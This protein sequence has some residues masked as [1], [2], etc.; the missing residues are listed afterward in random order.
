MSRQGHQEAL[1]KVNDRE[2]ASAFQEY[3]PASPKESSGLC[4]AP[5]PHVRGVGNNS[6]KSQTA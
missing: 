6:V 4:H 1:G 3:S 2:E 5:F